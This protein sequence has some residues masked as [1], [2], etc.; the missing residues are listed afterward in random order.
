M[1]QPDPRLL[2][3]QIP[4]VFLMTL[5]DALEAGYGK[6][7]NP[8]HNQIHAADVTQTVHC[9]LL[10]TGMVVC[11]RCASWLC[12][13]PLTWVHAEG[14]RSGLSTGWWL[15][16]G[17]GT[18]RACYYFLPGAHGWRAGDLPQHSPAA[19]PSS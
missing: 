16:G 7:K 6:Y 1:L 11:G 19:A 14:S 12:P 10:R 18:I 17:G 8:Y 5:L 15:M 3:P 2:A 4:T 13:G 9:F